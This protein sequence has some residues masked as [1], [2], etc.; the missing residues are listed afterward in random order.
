M[1]FIDCDV[2]GIITVSNMWLCLGNA[3]G[4]LAIARVGM[5]HHVDNALEENKKMSCYNIVA[6]KI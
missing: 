1:S 4:Q 6:M 3:V 5:P 2:Q